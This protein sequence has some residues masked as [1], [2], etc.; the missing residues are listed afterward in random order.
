MSPMSPKWVSSGEWRYEVLSLFQ[1]CLM[2][3]FQLHQLWGHHCNGRCSSCASCAIL[4][5]RVFMPERVS[6]KRCDAPG[7]CQG[8]HDMLFSPFVW[9]TCMFFFSPFWRTLLPVVSFLVHPFCTSLVWY[10]LLC[11][12]VDREA[13]V[14]RPPNCFHRTW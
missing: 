8:P 6:L 2:K 13:L 12:Y 7:C 3:L 14:Y 10:L 11:S 9:T 5:P 4:R 1:P